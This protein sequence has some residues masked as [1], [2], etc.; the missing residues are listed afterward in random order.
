MCVCVCVFV[1]NTSILQIFECFC[2]EFHISHHIVDLQI[3]DIN[4]VKKISKFSSVS[5][6][7]KFV[8]ECHNMCMCYCNSIFCSIVY[9]LKAN[10]SQ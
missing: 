3:C 8:D 1:F 5:G 6:K 10:T 4:P 9:L 7:P 2:I